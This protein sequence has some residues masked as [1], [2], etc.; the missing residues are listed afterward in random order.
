MV[1][2]IPHKQR[3]RVGDIVIVEDDGP[4]TSWPLGKITK[5]FPDKDNIIRKVEVFSKGGKYLRTLD[6]LIPLEL[7]ISGEMGKT[8]DAQ[9]RNQPLRQAQERAREAIKTLTDS[10]LV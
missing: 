1:L 2:K 3:N 10:Q 4:R 6:K 7:H 9:R 5:L 8:P